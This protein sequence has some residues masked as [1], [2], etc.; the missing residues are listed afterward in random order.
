MVK[1]SASGL[2]AGGGLEQAYNHAC[3]TGGCITQSLEVRV[4]TVATGQSSYMSSQ[5]SCAGLAPISLD[6]MNLGPLSTLTAGTDGDVIGFG[7]PDTIIARRTQVAN[8]FLFKFYSSQEAADA[9]AEEDSLGAQEDHI[10]SSAE[11]P[12]SVLKYY[13]LLDG[14]ARADYVH[15]QLSP[16][17]GLPC[18]LLEPTSKLMICLSMV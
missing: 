14:S 6:H 11:L 7:G 17:I 3:V 10:M 5:T 18:R 15:L 9:A 13:C 12:V 8:P 4:G 2:E 1:Q 16:V